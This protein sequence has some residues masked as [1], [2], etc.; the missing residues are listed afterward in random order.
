MADGRHR[1]IAAKLAETYGLQ[2]NAVEKTIMQDKVHVGKFFE[3]N[4]PPALLY[5]Y[6]A[7]GS[8]KPTLHRLGEKESFSGRLVY[9]SRLNPKGVSEKTVEADVSCSS[10]GAVMLR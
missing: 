10:H 8:A 4:G 2:E 3:P 6:E 1:F 7:V 9:F 5:V